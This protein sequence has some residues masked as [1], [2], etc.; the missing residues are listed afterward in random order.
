VFVQRVDFTAD[1]AGTRRLLKGVR[2]DPPQRIEPGNTAELVSDA[3][4]ADPAEI[5]SPLAL[6]TISAIVF[7][8]DDEGRTGIVSAA[9]KVPDVPV[10]AVSPRS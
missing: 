5:T 7:F 6:A 1:D 3:G 9:A 4:A 8:A 10:R 2:Y